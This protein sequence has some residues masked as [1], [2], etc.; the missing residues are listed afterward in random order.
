MRSHNYN[1]HTPSQVVALLES[2]DCLQTQFRELRLHLDILNEQVY[3]PYIQR[4]VQVIRDW[5]EQTPGTL[6][7]TVHFLLRASAKHNVDVYELGALQH[8]C[9]VVNQ[10][11]IFISVFLSFSKIVK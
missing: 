10:Y 8:L 7:E 4:A 3:G 5:R 2:T 6:A 9:D 1:Q 11:V